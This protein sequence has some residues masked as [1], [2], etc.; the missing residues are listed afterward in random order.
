MYY[1][2]L[3]HQAVEPEGGQCE[4]TQRMGPYD[5]AEAAANWR[6]TVERRNDA[7]DDEA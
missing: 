6:E 7:W 3:K 4:A 1:F 2:C 5:T